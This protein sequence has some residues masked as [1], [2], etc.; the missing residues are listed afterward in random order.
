MYY[1]VST[2]SDTLIYVYMYDG[3]CVDTTGGEM[4]EGAFFA[5]RGIYISVHTQYIAV[6]HI[7][8]YNAGGNEFPC[9]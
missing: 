9:L 5:G 7:I 3:E 8:M 1:N 4:G 6:I 2:M